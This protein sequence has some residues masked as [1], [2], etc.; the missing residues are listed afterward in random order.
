[1]GTICLNPA[2]C[3]TVLLI[4]M[5]DPE[6][7]SEFYFPESPDVSLDFVSGKLDGKQN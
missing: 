7:N 5:S 4:L 1:M 2:I 3:P 6:G